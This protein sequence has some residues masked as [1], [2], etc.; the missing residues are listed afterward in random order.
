MTEIETATTLADDHWSYINKLLEAHGA[1]EKTRQA[2][3]F[4]YRSA[5][6]H[7]FKHGCEYMQDIFDLD[8]ILE[9]FAERELAYENHPAK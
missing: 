6:V 2:V 3:G 7:G 8:L 5:F 1:S 4:H 9:E